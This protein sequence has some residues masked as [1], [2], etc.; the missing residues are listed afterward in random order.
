MR[1]Q[2]LDWELGAGKIELLK[3]TKWWTSNHSQVGN[4]LMRV[5]LMAILFTILYGI[6]AEFAVILVVMAREHDGG[7]SGLNELIQKQLDTIQAEFSRHMLDIYNLAKGSLE[8]D[9][10]LDCYSQALLGIMQQ[11]QLFTDHTKVMK[12]MAVQTFLEICQDAV[13]AV[14]ALAS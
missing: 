13:S 14:Y 8:N 2:H 3:F 7:I 10:D 6:Y 5:S 1:S 9:D 11:E 12:R 4:A